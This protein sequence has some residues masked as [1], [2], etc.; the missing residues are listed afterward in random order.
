MIR[1]DLTF[2]IAE[3]CKFVHKLGAVHLKAACHVLAYLTGTTALSGRDHLLQ[4][5][6]RVRLVLPLRVRE[7]HAQRGSIY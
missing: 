4:T 6:G 2:A 1:P 3:L 7:Q 5:P